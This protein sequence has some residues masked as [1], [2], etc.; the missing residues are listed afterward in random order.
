MEEEEE[1]KR[2]WLTAELATRDETLKNE[3]DEPQETPRDGGHD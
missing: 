2:P 3:Q 1:G